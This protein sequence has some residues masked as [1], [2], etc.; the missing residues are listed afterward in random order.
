MAGMAQRA[1]KKAQRG[2]RK[3]Q[4][5]TVHGMGMNSRWRSRAMREEPYAYSSNVAAMK[6]AAKVEL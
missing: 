3:R 6:L 2:C 4:Q 1:R 5:K